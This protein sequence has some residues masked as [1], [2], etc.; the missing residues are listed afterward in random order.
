MK[1]LLILILLFPIF[2]FSQTHSVSIGPSNDSTYLR[3]A[4]SSSFFPTPQSGTLMQ[5]VSS[6]I[7]T[8]A[9]LSMDD[10]NGTN[11]LGPVFQGRRAGGSAASPTS[12]LVDYTLA[13]LVGDGYGENS[14]TGNS[15]GAF[16]IKA[17]GTFTN[18]SKPT[19]LQM[20]TTPAGATTAVERIR[21]LST[22]VVRINGLN[23]TGLLH[24]NSSGDLSTALLTSGEVTTALGFTPYNSTNPSSFIT[25]S[26]LSPYKLISDSGRSVTSYATGFDLNKVR[27]SLQTNITAV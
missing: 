7:T 27:D 13:A 5:L 4:N 17:S 1:K 6:G 23:A 9:R 11:I 12:A 24:T 15:V 26:S 16:S 3:V 22:G 25:V 19:Y 21:I 8:N 20:L 10:Y 18:T 2:C 14:F